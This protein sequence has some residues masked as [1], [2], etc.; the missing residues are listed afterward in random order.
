MSNPNQRGAFLRGIMNPEEEPTPPAARRTPSVQNLVDTNAPKR[1]KRSDGRPQKSKGYDEGDAATATAGS[2][3]QVQP[4]QPA[5]RS[6]DTTPSGQMSPPP[7][8]PSHYLSSAYSA[9]PRS[10]AGPER[11]DTNTGQKSR[12][13]R[14]FKRTPGRTQSFSSH[15]SAEESP[16][17]SFFPS[18]SFDYSARPSSQASSYGST[19]GIGPAS[20]MLASPEYG[21]NWK[22]P[23]YIHKQLPPSPFQMYGVSEA[24]PYDAQQKIGQLPDFGQLRVSAPLSASSITASSGTPSSTSGPRDIEV[25][26]TMG[27]NREKTGRYFIPRRCWPKYNVKRRSVGMQIQSVAGAELMVAEWKDWHPPPEH[28]DV[29]YLPPATEHYQKTGDSN[30]KLSRQTDFFYV[31]AL[32]PQLA[33]PP[34]VVYGFG[35]IPN[36]TVPNDCK[37]KFEEG[38]VTPDYLFYRETKVD[39][40]VYEEED[41]LLPMFYRRYKTQCKIERARVHCYLTAE[42]RSHRDRY[43]SKGWNDRTKMKQGLATFQADKEAIES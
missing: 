25:E 40:D 9:E 14:S 27:P 16:N 22:E 43:V 29:I 8:P 17:A 10:Y 3:S 38:R 20:G 11:L 19:P 7:L 18:S 24:S 23:T 34:K 21:S 31:I 4:L 41:A 32:V 33:K 42:E 13:P 36:V 2:S 37:N 15:S 30:L 5:L 6:Y 26:Q 1:S 28:P 12:G 39:N 35:N